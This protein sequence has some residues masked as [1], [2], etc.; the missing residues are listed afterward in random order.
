[1]KNKLFQS[2]FTAA[3]TVFVLCL[4]LFV[5]V[6]Y[7]RMDNQHRTE[8]TNRASYLGAVIESEGTDLL[9]HPHFWEQSSDRI[10]L[11]SSDGTVILSVGSGDDLTEE[12]ITKL[13]SGNLR[14]ASSIKTDLFSA[15]GRYPLA[16]GTL[17]VVSG[18][19]S[20]LLVLLIEMLLPAMLIVMAAIILSLFLA[21]RVS[22]AIT[23]PIVRI[24][25]DSPDDRGMYE[26]LLPFLDKLREKNRQ[27]REH[28]EQIR[29]EHEKQ[30]AMRREFTAN[31]SHELK[32]PL[33]AISGTAEILQSGLVKSEDIPHFAGNI[34]REAARLISL[35][36][37][38]MQLSRLDENAFPDEKEEVELSALCFDVCDALKMKAEERS[39]A[40]HTDVKSA[41]VLGHRRILD[42]MIYNLID[43]A[44][45]YNRT[46]GEVYVSLTPNDS[47]IILT[48][49]DTGIGIPE[50]ELD[51]IFER[52]YRVDKSHSGTVE[53]TGLGLSIVKHGAKLHGAEIRTESTPGVGSTISLLFPLNAGLTQ[54]A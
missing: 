13:L 27:A 41:T 36:N 21:S 30:D 7:F 1:M 17:L 35:V 32:T 4:V 23:A 42:E 45:K 40:L 2:I 39:I 8:L 9:L 50:S 25:P 49:K 11:L 24:D 29:S 47:H 34:H 51:R 26:E 18:Q 53:G 48:V 12:E 5:T 20:P 43:N 10:S 46:G 52:F 38:I 31:V 6:L 28:L 44:I 14:S 15:H 22:T 54:I 3:M 33:T 19:S 16:D 37:D